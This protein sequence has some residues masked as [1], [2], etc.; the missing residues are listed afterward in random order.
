MS[1][2]KLTNRE[3]EVYGHRIRIR[4][5]VRNGTVLLDVRFDYFANL[6]EKLRK[7]VERYKLSSGIEVPKCMHPEVGRREGTTV[8]GY[9]LIWYP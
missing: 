5:S 2:A 4:L 8:R 1:I 9:L 7:C 3:G 6:F